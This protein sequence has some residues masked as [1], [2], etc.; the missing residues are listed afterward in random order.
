MANNNE[1]S[2]TLFWFAV[3][4]FAIYG[5]VIFWNHTG[6]NWWEK[7]TDKVEDVRKWAD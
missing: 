2:K 1:T 6:K 4:G 5:W 3:I 7:G